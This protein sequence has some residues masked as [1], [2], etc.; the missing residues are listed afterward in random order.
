MSPIIDLEQAFRRDRRVLLGGGETGVS[1]ELLDGAKVRPH[2]EQVGGV[3]VSQ[4]VGMNP[5]HDS[6]PLGRR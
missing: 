3:A 6:S 4:P 5:V 1:E 2:V